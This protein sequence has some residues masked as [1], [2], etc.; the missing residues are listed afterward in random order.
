MESKAER[1]DEV[2]GLRLVR[3]YLQLSPEKRQMVL[4]FVDELCRQQ[5]RVDDGTEASPR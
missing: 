2:Q 5:G 1:A 3:S 4:E